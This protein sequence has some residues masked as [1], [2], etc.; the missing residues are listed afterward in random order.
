MTT[1]GAAEPALKR[2]TTLAEIQAMLDP[3]GAFEKYGYPGF[4]HRPGQKKMLQA[5]AQA[6]ADAPGVHLS[7]EGGTGIGKSLAYLIPA[8]IHAAGNQT[9]PSRDQDQPPSR[10]VVITTNTI[11]LQDQ[12][13]EH[14]IPQVVRVLEMAGILQPGALR[15]CALKGESNYL[16]AHRWADAALNGTDQYDGLKEAVVVWAGQ[17][18]SGDVAEISLSNRERTSWE[19]VSARRPQNCPAYRQSPGTCFLAKA[20]QKAKAAHILVVNHALYLNAAKQGSAAI[21]SHDVVIV[22]EAH[23]FADEASKQLGAETS[24]HEL[25]A[26]CDEFKELTQSSQHPATTMA[27]NHWDI[28]WQGIR[29]LIKS[30]GEPSEVGETL[31]LNDVT[32]PEWQSTI[33]DWKSLAAPSLMDL[34]RT[35]RNLAAGQRKLMNISTEDSLSRLMNDVEKIREKGD[36][37]FD[38]T[39]DHVRMAKSDQRYETIIATP[40][41]VGRQL[42]NLIFQEHRSALL[43]SATLAPQGNFMPIQTE[44]G[45][46]TD[47]PTAIC[48][49]P[50]R[51][52]EQAML[53]S[54]RDL[55]SPSQSPVSHEAAIQSALLTLA[56]TLNGRTLALFTSRKAMVRVAHAIEQPLQEA[57]IQLVFQGR[58]GPASAVARTLAGN[59]RTLAMGVDAMWEGIDLPPA[60]LKAVAI[61]RLPFPVPSDP[62]IKARNKLYLDPFHEYYLPQ[63][64][65]R[66]RQGCGRLI[67]TDE[68]RGVLV[69][70]DP[71]I[72]NR[73]YGKQF[74][75]SIPPVAM[76]K[77]V[78]ANLADLAA[79][80]V[81]SPQT[82]EQPH[83][84]TGT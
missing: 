15:H 38:Q 81:G 50:F 3:G 41:Q 1:N 29:Q 17:T 77:S 76:Q 63:A 18:D 53:L 67:R 80:F 75:K 56:T 8:I 82:T 49:S 20:R 64:L 74:W 83:A 21:P 37:F 46:S 5:A 71:R 26:L 32:D 2:R 72:R 16:C 73:R 68:S 44:L 79:A 11:N 48:E 65:R 47:Q 7:V 66:F 55:P 58:N 12:L 31:D 84:G 45:V 22:D 34:E 39:P 9:S 6:L 27:I 19:K 59:P 69:I 60:S 40:L 62:V 57:G 70:L 52:Q 13:V 23:R 14:D 33:N 54:P 10:T 28:T 61:C 43:T 51:Y 35:L 30:H 42:K 25:P 24:Y 4:K 78:M 36:L